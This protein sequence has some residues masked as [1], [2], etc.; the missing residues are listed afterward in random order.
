MKISHGSE[1]Y[2]ARL[3]L[4][5]QAL[6]RLVAHMP[7]AAYTVDWHL[8]MLENALASTRE[9]LKGLGGSFELNPDFQR[10]NVWTDSRRTTYAEAFIRTIK[11]LPA[12]ALARRDVA[13][14]G[15]SHCRVPRHG[16]MGRKLVH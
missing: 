5:H 12:D 9:G 14:R 15:A 7:E 2:W 1:A 6:Y 13:S 11:P 3:S 16:P 4:E 10:G 8:N